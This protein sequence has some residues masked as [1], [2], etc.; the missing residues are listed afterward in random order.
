MSDLFK[1]CLVC[2]ELS[3]ESRCSEHR[4]VK[5]SN[6]V[7]KTDSTRWKKLSA[8]LRKLQPWCT[9]CGAT[10]DL[11]ADHIIPVS[12]RPE[13]VYATENIQILCRRCNGRKS[14]SPPSE[15]QRAEVEQRLKNRRK[16]RCI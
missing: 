6:R 11:C 5:T 10:N 3:K 16:P 12:E 7:V 15:A 1:P 9:E 8:K 14:G 13:L 2:G 4:I